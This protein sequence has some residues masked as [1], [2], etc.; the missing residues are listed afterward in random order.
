LAHT[1]DGMV[2]SIT[3]TILCIRRGWLGVARTSSIAT[4]KLNRKEVNGLERGRL[5]TKHIRQILHEPFVHE[6]FFRSGI[7]Y[8][9]QVDVT[10][11]FFS[12]LVDNTGLIKDMHLYLVQTLHCKRSGIERRGRQIDAVIQLKNIFRL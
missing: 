10:L 8:T 7:E 6:Y 4:R 1:R 11:E 2:G 9:V 5:R 12:G 3:V